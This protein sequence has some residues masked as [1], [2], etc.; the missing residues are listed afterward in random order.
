MADLSKTRIYDL[1]LAQKKVIVRC[2]F[3]VPVNDAGEITDDSRIK[4]ALPTIEYAL[5]HHA[6]VI[7]MSHFGR[8]KGKPDSRFSLLPV[9][10]RLSL[11]LKQE[12]YFANDP[13]VTG[14]NTKQ[15][16]DGLKSG[17]VMLLENVRFRGEEEENDPDFS[18]E[19]ANLGNVFINDAFGTAH[20]AHA[21]T[22]GIARYLPSAVGM[23]MEKEIQFL[24]KA[25]EDAEKPY[26]AI[27]GGAKVSDKIGIIERLLDRVDALLIGGGM[28]YTFLKA[29][30]YEIGKSLMEEDKLQLATELMR[31]A[32]ANRVKLVLPVDTVSA[33]AVSTDAHYQ[34][35]MVENMPSDGI[36]VDIGPQT[37]RMFAETIKTAKTVIWNGPM[38]V[39]EIDDFAAG[40]MEIARMLA[41][42]DA[43]TIIG[44]G[45]S[46]AA[47][48]KC[49][50]GDAMTH[51]STGGGASLEYLE[52]K[53]LP[54]IAAI[55]DK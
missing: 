11:L 19:L 47:V 31:K 54:G 36:G 52:G 8:P 5:T 42:S 3:N 6:A 34:I 13:Q 44:G 40:T 51:I 28:A 33:D 30:G 26:V 2:D 41:E 35:V 4:A 10:R 9:A 20:R 43:V 27:L 17:D 46:A 24:G 18:R 29:Q 21:S 50:F 32:K 55:P 48:E 45:D 53:E 39:F 49:G 38:G 7:L 16:A 23:L 22:A 12:V 14:E 37:V 15:M 1:E 25:L